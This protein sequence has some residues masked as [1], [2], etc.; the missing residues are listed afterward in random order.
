[1]V[2]E[3]HLIENVSLD[4]HEKAEFLLAVSQKELKGEKL[5]D[6]EYGQIEYMG[7]AFEYTTLNILREPNQYLSGWDDI[8]SA[9]KKIALV[10]DVYT[11]NSFNNPE[12]SV[13]YEAV[14][15]A[16]EIYVVVEIE[17][18]LYLTRGAVFSYRE[19]GEA[20]DAPRLTDEEW[21]QQLES[22]PDKGI[23]TWMEEIILPE[24]GKE[25]DNEHIF[26]SSGC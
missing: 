2:A 25:L 23:P 4:L 22:K 12:P 17:G 18:Y 9:D 15:P 13:L 14:G 26:Y 11:A 24:N 20:L 5:T 19:F 3:D 21:Q 8:Q 7:A 16:H 10:A 1:M 6:E